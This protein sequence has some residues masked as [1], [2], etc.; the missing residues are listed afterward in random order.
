M[1]NNLYLLFA[2]TGVFLLT[3]VLS[4]FLGNWIESLNILPKNLGLG[5]SMLF[6]WGLTWGIVFF[7]L[8][9]KKIL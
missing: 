8:K 2:I 6:S 4:T 5:L 3:A 1:K 9:K 7:Y